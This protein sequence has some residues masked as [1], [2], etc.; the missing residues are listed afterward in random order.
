MNSIYSKY[1]QKSRSFL[2]PILGIKKT[3]YAAPNGT[4]I[5][6]QGLID[7]DDVK[8]ICTFKEDNSESFKKFEEQMLITNPLFDRILEVD[9]YKLYIFDLKVYESDWFNFLLGKYSKLSSTMKRAIKLYY[10]ENSAEYKYMD[11]YLHPEKYFDDYA[12][13]L[14]V[15]VKELKKIGE[16]CDPCDLDKETLVVENLEVSKKD[17]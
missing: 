8:L 3:S 5:A 9:G 6:I 17:D 12:K 2:Y 10:G 15:D 13:I 16:L 4:Y 14:D 1:F 7:A 11:S